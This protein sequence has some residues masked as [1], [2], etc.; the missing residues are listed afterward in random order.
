MINNKVKISI[1]LGIVA[2]LC[3]T[4]ADVLLVGF[5]P[6]IELYSSF[7]DK[8]PEN[9]NS[10]LAILMLD[11]SPNRLMWG[12]YFATFSVFLYLLSVYGIKELLVK[13]ILSKIVVLSLFI[14]YA[15]SPVGHTGF[16]YIGLLSQNMQAN[17]TEIILAQVNLFEQFEQLLNIHWMISVFFSALGWLLLQIQILSK[18]TILNRWIILV[19]PIITAPLIAI[20]CS[21][22]PTN[23]IAVMFGCAS[24]NIS[25]LVFFF[26]VFI[27][28]NK[29]Y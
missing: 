22:F 10:N 25:Q 21:L 15:T 23:S 20:I 4:I 29:R 9:F 14:G 8:L 11:G 5:I 12:V 26:V 2:A 18:Q 13:N 1:F 7:I 16:A 24:L 28:L 3:W 6:N 19:N 27:V 17:N